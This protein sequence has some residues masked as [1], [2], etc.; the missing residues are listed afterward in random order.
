VEYIRIYILDKCGYSPMVDRQGGAGDYQL[1]F[2]AAYE[3]W[4]NILMERDWKLRP[5]AEASSDLLFQEFLKECIQ[6]ELDLGH[7]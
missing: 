7:Q 5:L 6:R 1:A 3:R 2:A 4:R